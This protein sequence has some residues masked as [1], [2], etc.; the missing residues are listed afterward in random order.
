MEN[1]SPYKKSN[2]LLTKTEADFYVYLKA[3]VNNDFHI[4]KMTRMCDLVD[5]DKRLSGKKYMSLFR[6][7]SQYHIDFTLCDPLTFKPVVCIELDDPSHE[8]S[9]RIK[10]DKKVNKIFADINLP[11]LRIKTENGSSLFRV[12]N[13]MTVVHSTLEV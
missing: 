2:N 11:L 13:G 6:S 3:A 9:A 10:R 4:N 12:G 5:V 7:I 8:R 1:H